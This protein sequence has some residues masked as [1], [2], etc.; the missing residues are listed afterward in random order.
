MNA[1]EQAPPVTTLRAAMFTIVLVVASVAIVVGLL[2]SSPRATG[3]MGPADLGGMLS[4][5]PTDTH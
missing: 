4:G 1:V 2:R 5:F 3:P